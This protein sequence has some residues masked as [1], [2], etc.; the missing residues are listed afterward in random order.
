MKRLL[1]IVAFSAAI[2]SLKAQATI[3]YGLWVENGTGI[4]FLA[5]TDPATGII[6]PIDTLNDVQAIVIQ[7]GT[8][9]PN[10]FQY[11]LRYLENSSYGIL[12]VGINNAAVAYDVPSEYNVV[13]LKY[14]CDNQLYALWYDSTELY[15]LVSIDPQT[16]G[17]TDLGVVPGLS[18]IYLGTFSFD[19]H[20]GYFMVRGIDTNNDSRLYTID[21]S[22]GAVLY[23]PISND[24]V[25]GNEYDCVT[26]LTYGL[27]NDPVNDLEYFSSIDPVTGDATVIDT[28]FPV[29]AIVSET[30]SL[31]PYIGQYTFSGIQGSS[32]HLY[33]VDVGSGAILYNVVTSDVITESDQVA[34]CGKP[35]IVEQS[36][37][38]EI[39][40]YPNPVKDDLVI[41]VPDEML[42][43]SFLEVTDITGKKIFKKRIQNQKE[44]IRLSTSPG[45]YLLKIVNPQTIYTDKIIHQ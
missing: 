41:E 25:R 18:G 20:N 26:H 5:S 8:I 30:F 28:L 1:L 6:T 43:E 29:A 14:G 40:V 12:T 35:T 37:N 2:I 24:N 22:T 16:G 11:S 19:T 3:I 45:I 36:V 13:G 21:A 4:T 17:Q 42:I 34:C 27:K 32:Y 38:R 39:Q 15:H 31:N 23:S 9:N 33:T 44:I 10:S 7:S